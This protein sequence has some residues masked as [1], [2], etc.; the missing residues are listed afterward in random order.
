MFIILEVGAIWM[1]ISNNSPQGAAFLNSSS[2]VF[3]S[4]LKK[5]AEVTQYFY[6]T[7]TNE[8]LENENLELIRRL[9]LLESKP[10]SVPILLDSSLSSKYQFRGAR[11]IANSLRFSQNYITL[12]K[13]ANDGIK[14][15]MGVFNAEGVVGRIKT[16][17]ENYAV[18]FSLLNTSLLI[19][20]KIK[21]LDVFGSVQWNGDNMREAKLLYIPRHVKT[22]EGDSV[23][24]S[25]FNAVFPEG[26]LIG[27]VSKIQPDTKDPNY[28]DLTIKLS[29]DF[30][31]LNYVYLVENN[32]IKELDSLY[33]K[34]ELTNEY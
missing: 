33:T 25:G 32:S 12:T 3:A 13:G 2:A 21:T 10:D 4:L 23:I 14:P 22:H 29:T 28:L 34:S 8:S 20:S 6:L 11:V 31:K 15:G 18:A 19:S 24:T 1:I 9:I 7:E 26:I 5:Q 27:I 16:V 30:S 17:S